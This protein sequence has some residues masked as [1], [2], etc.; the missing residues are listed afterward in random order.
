MR[1]A[2]KL[3]DE[4]VGVVGV[5]EVGVEGPSGEGGGRG[6]ESLRWVG[7]EGEESIW[8]I[9]LTVSEAGPTTR[10]DSDHHILGYKLTMNN[11]ELVADSEDE[12]AMPA[13]D[14]RNPGE[15][16]ARTQLDWS[17]HERACRCQRA[18]ERYPRLRCAFSFIYIRCVQRRL[19][20]PLCPNLVL[21][22]ARGLRRRT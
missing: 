13:P 9:T 8:W 18:Y 10:L 2:G 16:T 21:S 3:D 6:M 22:L 4:A 5:G 20:K 1:E 17:G 19:Q 7:V 15:P 11:D 14:V 12:L